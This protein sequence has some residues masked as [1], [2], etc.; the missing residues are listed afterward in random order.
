MARAQPAFV[1]LPDQRRI[2]IRREGGKFLTAFGK[3]PLHDPVKMQRVVHCHDHAWHNEKRLRASGFSD[4]EIGRSNGLSTTPELLR[5]QHDRFPEGQIV[6]AVRG[7][8]YLASDS[9]PVEAEVI[10]GLLS[11]LV[12][13]IRSIADIPSSYA[14]VTTNR[15]FALHTPVSSLPSD[16][17][18]ML[19]CVSVAID[20][21]FQLFGLAQSLLNFGIEF[22]AQHGLIAAPFSAPRGFGVFHKT[23]PDVPIQDYLEETWSVPSAPPLG[24]PRLVMP[25]PPDYPKY[26]EHLAFLNARRIVQATYGKPL[27]PMDQYLF[28]IEQKKPAGR[29]AFLEFKERFGQRFKH[30]YGR[31]PTI[32]DYIRYSGRMH[33]DPVMEMHIKNGADFLYTPDGRIACIFENG[34]PEDVMAAGYNIVLT[35]QPHPLLTAANR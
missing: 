28:E 21:P 15:T 14:A 16:A 25:A 34:R 31:A 9:Q 12:L 24:D 2:H 27:D 32:V 22:A 4:I 10:A 20:P 18:P 35:Y 13:P 3:L 8:E 23:H 26:L 11:T 33:I 30:V 19:F 5:E 29:E 7:H 17:V 1:E 6:I